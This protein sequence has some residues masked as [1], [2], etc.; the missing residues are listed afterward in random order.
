VAAEDVLLRGAEPAF[1]LALSK[2]RWEAAGG[3]GP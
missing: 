3:S 1:A 2:D